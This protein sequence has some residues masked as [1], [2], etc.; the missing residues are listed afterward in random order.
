MTDAARADTFR[1][2][3]LIGDRG[4][5]AARWSGSR[6]WRAA[7]RSWREERR[8]DYADLVVE[9]LAGAAATD[10][11]VPRLLTFLEHAEAAW[12]RPWR[13]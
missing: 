5:L 1:C 2:S 11:V 7:S 4:R 13:G 9:T 12:L 8:A 10:A 3:R 6:T